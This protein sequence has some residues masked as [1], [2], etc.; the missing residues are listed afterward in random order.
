MKIKYTPIRKNAITIYAADYIIALKWPYINF[1]D[2]NLQR[3]NFSVS[4]GIYFKFAFTR[5]TREF[6]LDVCLFGFGIEIESAE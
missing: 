1:K 3:I 2:F 5:A 6:I 4:L